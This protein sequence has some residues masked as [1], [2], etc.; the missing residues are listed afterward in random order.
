MRPSLRLSFSLPFLL[1]LCL[2]ALPAWAQPSV[3]I[4]TSQGDIVVELDSE[5]APNTVANFLEYAKSGHYD[6]T[7]FHRVIRRFMIQGGGLTPAMQ[8]KPGSRPAIR[9]EAD[10][11]LKNLKGTIAMARTGDPHSATDQFFINV[12]D[13]PF[14]DHR[15]RD[16]QG[17]GYAVFGKVV[18]GMDVA[19]KISRSPTWPGDVP[20]E[21]IL[22]E[23]V[24]LLK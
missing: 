6:G 22:I 11:G 16:E 23:S 5:K 18:S 20:T 21:T 14:L 10:N 24:T 9:N 4:K 12:V 7:I 19:E 1:A 15:A 17:W 3:K 2:T 8:E 13:N